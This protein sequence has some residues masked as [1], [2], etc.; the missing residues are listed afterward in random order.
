MEPELGCTKGTWRR[1]LLTAELDAGERSGPASRDADRLAALG[2]ENRE[3]KRA[4]DIHRMARAFFAAAGCPLH[5]LDHLT[6]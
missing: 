3:R 1:W 4:N 2:R 5:E 6:G